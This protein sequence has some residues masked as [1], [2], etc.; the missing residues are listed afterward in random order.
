MMLRA[1]FNKLYNDCIIYRKISNIK[2]VEKSQTDLD[3]LGNW[4][5]GNEMK[6]NPNKS[7]ALNFTRARVKDLL[8]Y[9]LGVQKILEASSCKYLGITIRSD[10]SWADQVNYTAQK[11][12]RHCTTFRNAYCKKG[13]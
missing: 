12:C 2:D 13:K 4:A 1:F 8:N 11:A 10:L 9:Y 7:K 3:R 5:E 6:I